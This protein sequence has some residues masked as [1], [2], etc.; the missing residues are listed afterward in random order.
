MMCAALALSHGS[1]WLQRSLGA[2]AF[3]AITL[4][5][6]GA[7]SAAVIGARTALR[8]MEEL[9]TT[10]EVLGISSFVAEADDNW[11]EHGIGPEDIK[12]DVAINQLFKKLQVEEDEKKGLQWQTP[13][14]VGPSIQ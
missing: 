7:S 5:N 8:I 9:C 10:G 1:C 14:L 12:V 6:N 11:L 4:G 13:W 3:V 2:K